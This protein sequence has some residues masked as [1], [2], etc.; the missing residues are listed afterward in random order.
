MK[1]AGKGYLPIVEELLKHSADINMQDC[2]GWSA[3]M[4][5]ASKGHLLI[6]EELLKYGADINMQ[7]SDGW[8]ALMFSAS[9]RHLPII[10][11]LKCNA[12][13]GM[14][15]TIVIKLPLQ[16]LEQPL[17]FNSH[18]SSNPDIMYITKWSIKGIN[19]IK[20]IIDKN[21]LKGSFVKLLI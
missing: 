9:Q 12:Y 8:S 17:W 20:D 19:Q 7:N 2:D 3:L 15:D 13:I 6:V 5:S 1:S 18:I 14:L 16:I 21:V 10:E 11:L 4:K